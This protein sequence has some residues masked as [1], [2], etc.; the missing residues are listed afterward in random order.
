MQVLGGGG[1]GLAVPK[2]DIESYADDP[3]DKGI[4]N[5]HASVNALFFV[6]KAGDLILVP[7]GHG[8]FGNLMMG[9][10]L[11]DFDPAQRMFV[12]GSEAY[13]V[14]FRHVHWLRAMPQKRT[15]SEALAKRIFNRRATIKIDRN[16]FGR[17]IYSLAYE[18][19]DDGRISK[20]TLYGSRYSGKDMRD[21]L[22]AINLISWLVAAFFAVESG[23]HFAINSE[24]TEEFILNY[25][26]KDSIFFKRKYIE[27]AE[28]FYKRYGG[29]TLIFGRF[30]P[31]VRT[32][33]PIL[34]GI[35]KVNQFIFFIYNIIGAFLWPIVIS[36]AGYYIGQFFPQAINYL[37]YI[38]IAF[39]LVTSIPI[40]SSY[41]KKK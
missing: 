35:V 19:F 10:V 37:N 31:I 17:E 22:G 20:A 33:A 34:A 41:L 28:D 24:N 21:L 38:I 6:A 27:S 30:L 8:Q 12:N 5:L 26:K 7:T 25:Y 39:V 15:L 16:Q 1:D 4:S 13:S 18:N 29:I 11:E 2:S 40:I 9:E 14:Q 23:D 32:F 36:G 3:L